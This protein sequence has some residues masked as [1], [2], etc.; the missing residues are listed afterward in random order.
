MVGVLT[1]VFNSDTVTIIAVATMVSTITLLAIYDFGEG[2]TIFLVC[3]AFFSLITS[4]VCLILQCWGTSE[5]KMIER[6]LKAATK[7]QLMARP[8]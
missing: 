1:S 6:E 7:A 5:R 2:L 3:A 4:F 8:E